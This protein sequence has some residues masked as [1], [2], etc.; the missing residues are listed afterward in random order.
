M[1]HKTLACK[2]GSVNTI[3]N[4]PRSPPRFPKD[5]ALPMQSD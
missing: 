5:W 2:V 4:I 3:I 1:L